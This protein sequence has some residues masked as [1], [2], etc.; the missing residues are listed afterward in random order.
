MSSHSSSPTESDKKSTK[1]LSKQLTRDFQALS[2]KKLHHE[3]LLK[4]RDA[5]F[6]KIEEELQIVKEKGEYT[7]KSK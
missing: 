5:H 4:E 6:A 3:T 7:T 2:Y 1:T